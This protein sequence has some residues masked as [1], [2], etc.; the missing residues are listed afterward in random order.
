MT[1]TIESQV[2][3]FGQRAKQAVRLLQQAS[4][5]A[6][7]EALAYMAEFLERDSDEIERANR[8]DIR[9]AESEGR[10]AS[11]IDRLVLNAERIRAMAEGLRQIAALPD[12]VGEITDLKFRPS[13]IQVGKMRVPIGVIGMIYESRPNVTADAAGLCLKSGNAVILRGGSEA[14][15]SNLAIAERLR[16]ALGRAKLPLD[17]IQVLNTPDRAAVGA[18]IRI[19]DY[20][21]I[22]IPRGG[23]SLIERI[24][25]E[26]TVPVIKHLH[27]NCHVYVDEYA[28]LDKAVRIV[29]NAKAQRLGTCNT[30]E[31]LL[32]HE[33]VATDML[34]PI[35][36]ALMEK[37][38]ELRVDAAAQE[39][40]PEATPATEQDF[41]TEY[42]GPIISVKIVDSLDAAMAHI[43]QYGS[44]HSEAIVTEDYGHA[45]R[46]LREVDSSSVLVNASTRFADGF[47][48]GLGAEIGISTDK[49]HVRGPVGLEGLTTQKWI[50]LG[51][52][53]V[54]G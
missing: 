25:A 4:T 3:E 52:G 14:F 24:S 34:P 30:A 50:V 46:F 53:H 5:R 20:V 1:D 37:G 42:L 31:S 6:K 16:A 10:D 9:S 27:G 32:V 45:R 17:A 7:N 51:D 38:I 19:K 49:L 11:F 13:G 29:V 43:A 21:D 33:N 40:L 44:G 15:H 8:K 28:N 22:I 12:P 41:Y 36:Q 47:E 26:A 54:R 18:L 39:L 2:I 23:K 48:Y 35:A